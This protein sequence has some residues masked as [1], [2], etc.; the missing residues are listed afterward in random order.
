MITKTNMKNH[1]LIGS[2]VEIEEKKIKGVIIDETKNTFIIRSKIGDKVLP[3]KGN[4]FKIKGEI[5]I[6]DNIMQRPYDRLRKTYKVKNKWQE[7]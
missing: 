4:I 7:K 5:I 6:G 1:E 2:K 3:K